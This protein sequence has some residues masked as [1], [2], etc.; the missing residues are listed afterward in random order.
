MFDKLVVVTLKTRL[1]E[2][3][4]RFNTREQAKFYIEH[5]GLN[6][7]D[8]E[9]EHDTY[10]TA[11]RLLRR[12]LEGLLSKVQ[13]IEPRFPAELPVHAARSRRHHRPRRV[14][15]QRGEISRRPADCRR[16]SR[17][18]AHRRRPAAVHAAQ[19]ASRRRQGR[20]GQG[21]VSRNH[22]GSSTPQRRPIAPGLQ[23]L[24]PRPAHASIVALQPDV[25]QEDGA[26]FVQR[27]AGRHRSRIDG[28][29]QLDAEHGGVAESAVVT[30]QGRQRLPH[31]G[32]RGTIRGWCS[33]CVSR[34]RA[35]RRA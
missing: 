22:D 16:Q 17:L 15:R 9:R 26:S 20:R 24:L 29:V 19:G 12:Q 23:R 3:I 35:R 18:V 14:S 2:L 21:D 1:E 10:T 8:Y 28:L 34:S 27:R 33:W 11:V 5:M 31:C 7:A 30:G 25:S 6:F 32:C 13:F 4:E